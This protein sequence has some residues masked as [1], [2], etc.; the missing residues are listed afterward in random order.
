VR[1]V[2]FPERV[3]TDDERDRLLVVHRHARE[4]FANVGRGGQRVGVA[5][6]SLGIDVDQP[7]LHRPERVREVAFAAVTLVTEPRVFF[8]P[9]D[10]VRFPY[11]DAATTEAERCEAHRLERTVAR[12]NDEVT[13]RQ[14]AS[15]LLL[16]GPQQAARL[17]EV[18]VVGPAVEW[19]EALRTAAASV[20]GAIRARAVPR[21]PNEQRP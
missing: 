8:A 11:V 1:A 4:R 18:R 6:R 10:L 14:V 5:V 21:H 17:V 20:G 16:H 15:V 7:H 12:E 9:E 3:A 19:R 13:P 2:A